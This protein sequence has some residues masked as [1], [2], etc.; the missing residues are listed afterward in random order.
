MVLLVILLKHLKVLKKSDAQLI[1]R[2][3]VDLVLP[4]LLI[5]KLIYVDIKSSILIPCAVI[6]LTEL[7]VGILSYLIG[8]NILRLE[9]PSLAVF[10]LCSTFGSTA[11]IGTAFITAIFN[12]NDA[13]IADALLIAELSNGIPG[14]IFLYIISKQFGVNYSKKESFMKIFLSIIC[15]PPVAAIIISLTWSGLHLPTSGI[16]ITPIIN[17]ANYIGSS[18]VL[19][20]ALLNGLAIGPI[21]IRHHIAPVL[22]CIML[23]LFIK[24]VIVYC[25]NG[26]FDLALKDRQIS[27]IESA[28]PSANAVI[29]YAIRYNCDALLAAAL[30]TSTAIIGAFTLPALMKYLTIFN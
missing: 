19:M 4:A 14:Y 5:S 29:A 22:L 1:S 28:M 15:S 18:L 20:I 7:L 23:A 9:R 30:V 21:S 2:L 27:V 25:L 6:V 12:G 3:T 17:S 24:P 13:T 26:S 11:I 8:K 16:L 10:I